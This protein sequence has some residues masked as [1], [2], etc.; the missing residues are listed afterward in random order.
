MKCDSAGYHFKVSDS[1][2]ANKQVAAA[3]RRVRAE[4]RTQPEKPHGVGPLM[5]ARPSS[6]G[7][8]KSGLAA[9]RKKNIFYRPQSSTQASFP[10]TRMRKCHLGGLSPV[11]SSSLHLNILAS[12]FLPRVGSDAL[13]R[14]LLQGGAWPT[15]N[16]PRERATSGTR[17]PFGGRC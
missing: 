6:N 4:K 3:A 1:S 17:G 14:L 9:P 16:V 8:P 2:N 7:A 15:P 10:P 13:C 11:D 12:V 5:R